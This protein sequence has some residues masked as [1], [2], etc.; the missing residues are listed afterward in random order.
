MKKYDASK[1]FCWDFDEPFSCLGS[2]CEKCANFT[3]EPPPWRCRL[4]V[5]NPFTDEIYS[6]PEKCPD[7]V[8]KNV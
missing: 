4:E 2:Q 7:F 3:K 1:K 5:H 6:N 8:E